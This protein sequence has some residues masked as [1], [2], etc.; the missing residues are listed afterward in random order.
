MYI[1]CVWLRVLPTPVGSVVLVW[2]CSTLCTNT[3]VPNPQTTTGR[4]G[5]SAAPFT[6]VKFLISQFHSPGG[7]ALEAA[8][9]RSA[10]GAIERVQDLSERRGLLME[11]CCSQF[12]FGLRG[13]LVACSW[14]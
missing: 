8:P 14:A 11:L 6:C 13:R 7:N 1:R 2:S 9:L 3:T 10:K 12:M 4:P 5:R